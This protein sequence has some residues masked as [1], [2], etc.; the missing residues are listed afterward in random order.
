MLFATYLRHLLVRFAPTLK[1]NHNYNLSIK[2][3]SIS[4]AG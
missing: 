1:S 4:E 3:D 2:S